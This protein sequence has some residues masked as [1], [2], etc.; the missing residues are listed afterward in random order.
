MFTSSPP[1]GYVEI[2][3][4]HSLS[5][6]LLSVF[7]ACLAS[8]TALSLNERVR[9]NGFFHP[10]LWLLLASFSMGF[11]IW[12][13]HF[14]GMSAFSMPM[15]M[16]FDLLW[17]F[18][19]IAPAILASFLAFYLVSRPKHSVLSFALAGVTL[20]IGIATMHYTGMAA[21]ATNAV[22]RY[23][24]GLFVLSI[25]IAVVV[26]FV[27][28]FIFSELRKW[29]EKWPIKLFT[30]L[31]MG[32]AVSS[33]HYTG[34]KAITFFAS[35]SDMAG[36]HT[37][38]ANTNMLIIPIAFGMSF[39][40]ILLLF[41]SVLD[42]Y[43][44]Y[45]ISYFDGPTRLPNRRLFEKT[46]NK[47]T[48]RCSLAIWHFQNLEQINQS[49]GYS[50]GEKV[51][52]QIACTLREA[53]PGFTDLY[54]IGTNRF[55][56]LAPSVEPDILVQAM[57]AIALKWKEPIEIEEKWIELSSVCSVSS[58]SGTD[59]PHQLYAEALA[60]LEYPLLSYEH[61]VVLF[62]PS[63]HS[64]SF[65]QEILSGLTRAMKKD[66]LFLVY[67]P[68]IMADSHRLAGFEALI[69]WRHMEHG[70]LSPGIFIP[71]LEQHHRINELT[72]WVI[73]R[74]A[75]QIAEWEKSG[76]PNQKI[77][78][79]IPGEYVTSPRLK[80][81]LKKTLERYHINPEQ[82]ELEITETSVAQSAESAIRAIGSF[83]AQGFPVALDDFGT[84][85]SSLSFLRQMPITTLKI[86]KSFVD[87]VPLSDKDSAILNAIITLGQSLNL[88]IVIEGV[89]KAE[90]VDFLT[91]TA[92]SLIV[93]GYYYAKPMVPDE[94]AEWQTHFS[95]ASNAN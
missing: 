52:Q 88:H 91:G 58:V 54:R 86:D 60:V 16:H 74:A 41:S 69:R 70:M 7:I 2:S 38:H 92:R 55:A 15:S 19:S 27:A 81:V 24:P 51:L 20:G 39:L 5:L 62:N 95:A 87:Q 25:V 65:E 45:R 33:M 48:E 42:R 56:F 63:V 89:E 26:S 40:L 37:A 57:K 73:D 83:R 53:H 28:L 94:L 79:N 76:L 71:I 61:E 3:G 67:Q 17:T 68:K 64:F 21:M 84:G 75:R 18:F 49:Y 46:L 8:Y 82:L 59:N 93:Q 6:V 13:M 44:D 34:M 32:L 72:D 31:L 22:Y 29:M 30:S 77:A 14:I 12:S 23:H 1:S 11:G 43:I 9:K 80:T 78:V 47:P 66:E 10:A 85:V 4:D 36:S 90:Q 50:F 35:P